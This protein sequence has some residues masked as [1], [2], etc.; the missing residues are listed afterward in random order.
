ME[1]YVNARLHNSQLTKAGGTR[2]N[3]KNIPKGACFPYHSGKQCNAGNACQYQHK[4]VCVTIMGDNIHFRP[5]G[6]LFKSPFGFCPNSPTNSQI[7]ANKTKAMRKDQKVQKQKRLP[8]MGPTPIKVNRLLQ[9]LDGYDEK[10]SKY[11]IDGFSN[12]QLQ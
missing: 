6:N 4:F 7:R 5:A 9:W 2:A 1:L 8:P 10:E 12:D 3:V 11:L